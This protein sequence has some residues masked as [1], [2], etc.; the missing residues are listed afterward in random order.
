MAQGI[1]EI[2]EDL[3]KH[4]I[5][6][7]PGPADN[8]IWAVEN[9]KSVADDMEAEGVDWETSNKDRVQGWQQMRYLFS[10][11]DE[12]A[13]LI[14]VQRSC[15]HWIRTVPLMQRDEKNWDDIET[16][17][18]DHICFHPTTKI[19]TPDGIMSFKKLPET[20]TVMTGL[21]FKP[22]IKAGVIKENQAA[23]VLYGVLS[24]EKRVS[25]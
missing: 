4:G 18:E 9:D 21:G 10:P 15:L 22:Y 24:L 6:I 23:W 5:I 14:Y 20:G 12:E 19:L 16:N 3:K 25:R 8:Q 2:E 1:L 17:S 7:E 11:D 13:P